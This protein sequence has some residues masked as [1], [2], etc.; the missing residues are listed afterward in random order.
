MKTTRISRCRKRRE[1]GWVKRMLRA[2]KAGKFIRANVT[3]PVN[4][5][6]GGQGKNGGKILEALDKKKRAPKLSEGGT[7]KEGFWGGGLAP[8]RKIVG[9]SE[10]KKLN[11]RVWIGV[12]RILLPGNYQSQ[13]K[14]KRREVGKK[15]EVWG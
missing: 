13:T 3:P 8:L 4:D 5:G 1:G 12:N 7:L 10:K 9:E 14:T 11:L 15:K 6:A 2:E